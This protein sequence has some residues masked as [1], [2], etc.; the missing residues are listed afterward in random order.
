[1]NDLF[2]KAQ[3]QYRDNKTVW[4]EQKGCGSCSYIR[5]RKTNKHIAAHKVILD[6]VKKLIFQTAFDS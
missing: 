3:T 6:I 5:H 4:Q 2:A 1:M